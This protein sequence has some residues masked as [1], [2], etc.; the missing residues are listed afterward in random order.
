MVP[1]RL[2]NLEQKMFPKNLKI[3]LLVPHAL[4]AHAKSR[5]TLIYM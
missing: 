2:Q 1:E 3:S 4:F 5:K